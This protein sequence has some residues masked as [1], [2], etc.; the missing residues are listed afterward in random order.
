MGESL[1]HLLRRRAKPV[2][3]TLEDL[4]REESEKGPR[5]S[6]R[7]PELLGTYYQ[8]GRKMSPSLHNRSAGVLVAGL[9]QLDVG[10]DPQP[11]Y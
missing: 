4:Q 2:G 6:S 9:V 3:V 10:T 11:Q 7:M 1:H 8:M 5:G